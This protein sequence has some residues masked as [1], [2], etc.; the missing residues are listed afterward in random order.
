MMAQVAQ[1]AHASTDREPAR[2]QRRTD[3]VRVRVLI[4]EPDALARRM[5]RDALA[6]ADDVTVVAQAANSREAGEYARY[7]RPDV[8]LAEADMPD[9]DGAELTRRLSREAPDARVVL[10][11]ARHDDDLALRAIRAGAAG[12]LTKDLDPSLL[13]RVARKVAD[14]EA[15]IPRATVMRVLER[16][17]EVPDTGWRPVRSRLTSREWEMVDLLNGGGTTEDIA[18]QLVLSPAT[19]YSHVKNLL[20]KLGVHS[21][22]E[23]LEA[24]ER[25]RREEAAS[26][27]S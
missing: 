18:E 6:G 26:I 20:R 23:A 4:V 25:L 17:R 24:A 12:Y 27:D 15:A 16:M 13:P 22:H 7:H 11:S 1:Q 5:V 14:G 21:R 10:L 2:V 8:V 9:C 3:H 19:V